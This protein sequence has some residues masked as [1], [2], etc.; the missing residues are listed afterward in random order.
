M[1]VYRRQYQPYAGRLTSTRSRFLVLPRYGMTA[2]LGSRA[3][4]AFLMLTFMPILLAGVA[5]YLSHNP[6]ARALLRFVKDGWFNFVGANFFMTALQTQCF[7]AFILVAWIGPGL[8]APDLA[9]GALPLFLSRPLSRAEYVLGK[10]T[11]LV[12][13]LSV[14]TWVPCLL[15]YLLNAAFADAGW[16]LSH[17][18]IVFA[19]VVSGMVWI[20][21]M[22]LF[23]LALSAFIKWRLGASAMLFGIFFVS[24]GLG[25]TAAVAL[26]ISW[27]RLLSVGH[28]F[29]VVSAHL[30][31]V[32]RAASEGPVLAAW[33]A[34]IGICALSLLILHQRLRAREVVR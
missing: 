20:T 32:P 24:G 33:L 16:W 17:L 4:L 27:G 6:A 3:A 18:R 7:L 25:E 8:I 30:F 26:H 12:G 22:T 1:A 28:L 9:N 5:I 21:V 31:G 34:L 19:L 14:I 29:D 11:L 23:S 2:L 10:A 15:L 13:L